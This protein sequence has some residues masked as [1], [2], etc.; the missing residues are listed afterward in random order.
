MVKAIKAPLV[1]LPRL[2]S[3]GELRSLEKLLSGDEHLLA[4]GY[5]TLSPLHFHHELPNTMRGRI[6]IELLLKNHNRELAESG[7]I[8]AS[9]LGFAGAVIATGLFDK[10]PGMPMPVYDLDT[11]QA[12]RL[13]LD[14]KQNGKLRAN[15]SIGVRAASV[16]EASRARARYFIDN[17]ADFIVITD[18]GSVPGLEERTI[19]VRELKVSG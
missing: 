4:G 7:L 12:L 16:S 6:L 11:S 10:H 8:T 18:G 2:D 14:L 19:P 1:Y 15:F 5:G 9:M 17:G 13:A 3:I